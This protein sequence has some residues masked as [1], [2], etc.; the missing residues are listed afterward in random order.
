[1]GI[2]GDENNGIRGIPTIH[3]NNAARRMRHVQ[4]VAGSAFSPSLAPCAPEMGH[5]LI[6]L[7]PA[8]M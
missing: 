7:A 6:P 4:I 1:M 3:A 5:E 8:S 2:N